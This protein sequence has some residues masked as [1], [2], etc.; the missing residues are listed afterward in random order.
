MQLSRCFK[1]LTGKCN[2]SEYIWESN[3]ST[4]YKHSSGRCCLAPNMSVTVPYAILA[5]GS[6]WNKGEGVTV[7]FLQTL[8]L[9]SRNNPEWAW[10][11]CVYVLG[12]KISS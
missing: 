6:M 7:G 12:S 8:S 2:K 10:Y 5:Y 11:D 4:S 9:M 3:N 1:T